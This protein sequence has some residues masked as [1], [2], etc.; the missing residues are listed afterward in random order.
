MKLCYFQEDNN[1]EVSRLRVEHED[2][3]AHLELTLTALQARLSQVG[4]CRRV[5]VKDTAVSAGDEVLPK[6][7]RTVCV[8]T[9]RETFVKNP[10]DEEA[11][12]NLKQPKVTPKKLDLA[13]IRLSL[14]GQRD[15]ALASS[16]SHDLLPDMPE[17]PTPKADSPPPPPSPCVSTPQKYTQPSNGPPAIPVPPPPPLPPS[18]VA[19]PPP[20]PPGGS[21]MVDRPP[22]KAAV[23][24]TRPMKPLYWNRIQIQ[25]NK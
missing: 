23:E 10:A 22:R 13:S 14:A 6:S 25:D 21:F 15:D 19:P 17:L 4:A 24:P 5:D 8:Q 9:D 1:Q 12:G 20:P 7:F 2:S 16:L 3:V 18:A 11:A